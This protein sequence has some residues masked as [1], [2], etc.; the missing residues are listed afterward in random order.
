MSAAPPRVGSLVLRL[1]ATWRFMTDRAD[2]NLSSFLRSKSV[3]RLLNLALYLG[4]CLLLGTGLLLAFRLPH[5]GSAA[6]I[7]R[8]LGYP[9]H[10]WAQAHLWTSYAIVLLLLAHLTLHWRWLT[11]VAG[12]GRTR[13]LVAGLLLGMAIVIFF[14]LYPVSG[15]GR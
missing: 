13:R 9:L 2:S 10:F 15:G 5:G 8:F 1:K 6:P 12:S 14:L 11:T 4:F 7:T 3:S